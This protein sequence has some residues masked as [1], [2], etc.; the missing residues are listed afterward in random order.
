MFVFFEDHQETARQFLS[1]LVAEHA[2]FFRLFCAVSRILIAFL[3]VA[4]VFRIA[5]SLFKGKKQPEIWGFLNLPNGLHLPVHHWENL[6][7]R[8]KNCDLVLNFP[9]VSRNHAALIR[10]DDG[11]WRL[12]DLNSKTGLYLNKTKVDKEAAAEFGD[13]FELGGIEAQ[14]TSL[15]P[16]E[17][18]M[19]DSR[20]VPGKEVNPALT[21]YLLTVFELVLALQLCFASPERF[22]YSV[23]IS[24]AL[25]AMVMWI[26]FI[27]MRL[28]RRR[29]FEVEQIAFF[30]SCIGLSV[31]AS[32]DPGYIFKQFL[33]VLIGLVIFILLG[34]FLRDH[35][36]ADAMR[37]PMGA[38]AIGLLLAAIVFGSVVYGAKNWIFIGGFSV[39]PSELS[40]LCF[41]YAGTAS[42]DRLFAKRNLIMYMVLTVCIAGALAYTSDFGAALIFFVAFLVVAFMRSGD[43]ATLSLISLATVLGGVLLLRFKPYIAY[44]FE[45]WRHVWEVPHDGGFQQTRTMSAA[46][47]GGLFGVGAG[48]GWLKNIVAADTDLVFGIVAEELGLIVGICCIACVII[49]AV[50]AFASSSRSRSTFYSISASAATAMLLFQTAL[51][52]FGS[53]DILPLTGVTF[54]FVSNGGSS[55]MSCF[56]MLAFVK[57]TDTRRLASFATKNIP[58]YNRRKGI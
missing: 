49:L 21:M 55:L 9:S 18:V 57:A 53:L 43:V 10:R 33:A 45:S 22:Y 2:V 19:Q 12:I 41:I 54:P 50:F 42:L 38:A 51:N 44:R 31:I 32:S 4:I 26:Y 58:S 11:K 27:F 52:V 40:K 34:W 1:G 15:T 6:I 14:F 39:Q 24:F 37:W 23:P 5:F 20:E 29:G 35:K 16:A 7:G 28:M 8:A 48:N 3:A 46:A 56:G 30:L 17:R 13:V 47:S 25:L 36:R